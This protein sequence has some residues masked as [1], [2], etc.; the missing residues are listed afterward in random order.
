MT[1]PFVIAVAVLLGL[2]FFLIREVRRPPG[3]REWGRTPRWRKPLRVSLDAIILLLGLLVFW[4][5]F[6]EPN[7][8]VLRQ[9]TIQIESW[10]RE[11]N[12]LRIA[13]IADIHA[14]APFIDDEKLRLIVTRTNDLHPDLIVIL[15]DY[16]TVDGWGRRRVKPEEFAPILKDF[17]APLGVYSVLGNHDW[18]FNGKEVRRG[19][20]QNG[21][22][23]LEDEVVQL[24]ARGTTLWLAGLADLWTRPQHIE[25]TINKVPEGAPVI[26]LTH[27]PDIFPQVSQRV[28]LLLAGHTH[29]GQVRFPLIG[30]VVHSSKLG[31]R[32]ES[33]HVFENNHH[34]FVTTGIGTSIMPVRFGVP[35]EIVLVT[36]NSP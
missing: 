3:P 31:K 36:V 34:L 23:V 10:P 8:L 6:I 15:G 26:A 12:G 22:K 21:M 30:S 28:P 20:E 27:N 1:I 33:G 19:L 25:E 2:L 7:R 14:G 24:N 9:Q 35:P 13:V 29:G 5:F 11:L 32:Y 16:M 17:S 4:S 18:W